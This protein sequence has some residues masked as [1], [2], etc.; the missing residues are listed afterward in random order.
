MVEQKMP[1]GIEIEVVR[2][3]HGIPVPS[4]KNISPEIREKLKLLHSSESWHV[5]RKILNQGITGLFFAAL[6]E[7]DPIKMS[8]V[9]G[10]VAGMN[11]AINQLDVIL[12]PVKKKP[13]LPSGEEVEL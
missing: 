2:D 8:K 5:Y 13:I 12:N 3:Q 9:L 6:A 4:V 7:N 11:F 10:Q 1:F